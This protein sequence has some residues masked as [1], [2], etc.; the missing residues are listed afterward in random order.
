M[1]Y[2][3]S[4]PYFPKEDIEEILPKISDILKGKGLLSMGDNVKEF[5]SSFSSFLGSQEAIATNSCSSALEISLNALGVGSGDEVIVPAQTFIATGSSVVR[6][7]AKP[8]FCE[9]NKNFLIDFEDL[10]KKIN[11]HTKAVVIVHFAGLI[12]E[13]I[14][15]IRKFLNKK[16]IFLIED[17]AHA[18]GSSLNGIKA[19]NFG[20]L[21]CFSFFSTKNMTTGEGG[22]I[23]SNNKDLSK[24]CSSIRNRGL[25]LDSSLEQFI[26]IGSN[27]RMT[28]I[29]A[30]L[31]I[32]QLKRI[33]EFNLHRN[34]IAEIYNQELTSFFNLDILSRHTKSKDNISSYWKY[35][36]SL[37]EGYFK[38]SDRIKIKEEMNAL[39]IPIDWAYSPLLHLQPVF[40][41]MYNIREGYLPVSEE[42]SR[43]HI[44]LP[45][46]ALINEEDAVF[47]IKKFAE[48]VS[49]LTQV[50]NK[51]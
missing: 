45:I 33:Q 34:K 39:S 32:Y 48:I 49:R 42:I 38:S 1:K 15:S 22:M 9:I 51:K 50:N 40:K 20:D 44:C 37:E 17:A 43:R 12:H 28:E 30:L 31:G 14:L 41:K 8:I 3:T 27:N 6:V 24:L 5:E 26:N 2:R 36:V 19:G 21:S 7:G 10:K 46:H 23:V 16:G 11:K 35:W 18:I 4:S 25:D 13:D 47:I 29:Q